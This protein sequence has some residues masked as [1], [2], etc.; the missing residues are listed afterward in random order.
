MKKLT[1]LFVLFVSTKL[2]AQAQHVAEYTDSLCLYTSNFISTN[3]L[4]EVG[5]IDKWQK[6]DS[7]FYKQ[8]KLEEIDDSIIMIPMSYFLR[9]H[10][11]E[12]IY[13]QYSSDGYYQIRIVKDFLIHQP[14]I[15]FT[16]NAIRILWMIKLN[17]INGDFTESE[18]PLK[19]LEINMNTLNSMGQDRY[20]DYLNHTIS[21]PI[22][23]MK[24]IYSVSL[25]F[26]F[27]TSKGNLGE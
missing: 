6:W 11:R 20:I 15:F 3:C 14:D 13:V 17:I 26:K 23:L 1:I 4:M 12:G 5:L 2:N 8:K 18:L 10:E 21:D 24:Q 19:E 25:Y 16:Y 7:I 9:E 27:S 22:E